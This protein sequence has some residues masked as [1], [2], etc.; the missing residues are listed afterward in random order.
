MSEV[1][2]TNEQSNLA[3]VD[4]IYSSFVSSTG[5][6]TRCMRGYRIVVTQQVQDYTRASGPVLLTC[7]DGEDTTAQLMQPM[8][9]PP[10]QVL[11][12]LQ[13]TNF[14][15]SKRS[16]ECNCQSGFPECPQSAGGDFNYRKIYKLKT[17]DILYDLTSRNMTDW[18]VKTELN[19]QFFKKRFGGF[20]FTPPLLTVNNDFAANFFQTLNGKLTSSFLK[21][22]LNFKNWYIEFSTILISKIFKKKSPKSILI[23]DIT[24]FDA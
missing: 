2:N 1:V 6:G 5:P 13:S 3:E 8:V 15:Y 4:R 22:K 7:L 19:S 20:E 9:Q 16:P 18:L 17:M 14:S 21:E 11:N 23:S 10:G 24:E 12:E